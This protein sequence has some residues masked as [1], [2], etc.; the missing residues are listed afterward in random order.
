[1]VRNSILKWSFLQL[2]L[3]INFQPAFAAPSRQNLSHHE[4]DY[5][6]VGG[7]PA[8]LVLVE[9]LTLHPQVSVLLLEAGPDSSLDPL[10]SSKYFIGYQ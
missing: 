2:F 6:V 5:V 9:Q 8:G 10:V 3:N 4:Y 7:G 1:M